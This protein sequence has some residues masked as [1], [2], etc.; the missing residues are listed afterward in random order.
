MA[1]E[2]LRAPAFDPTPRNRLAKRLD[3]LRIEVHHAQG[4]SIFDPNSILVL[5]LDKGRDAFA[6][7]AGPKANTS[8]LSG[9]PAVVYRADNLE[10]ALTPDELARMVLL[11]L[12]PD[13]YMQLLERH[14]LAHEWHEDFYDYD[15]YAV[16]PRHPKDYERA[17]QEYERKHPH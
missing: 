11:E 15:G 14:G 7:T 2:P 12:M 17:L 6:P 1:K 3:V 13:E 4:T 8:I 5:M 16:Q 9:G 10:L